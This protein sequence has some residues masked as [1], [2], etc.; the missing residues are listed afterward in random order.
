MPLTTVTVSIAAFQVIGSALPNGRVRFELTA[1]DIDDGIVVP[2]ATTVELAADGTGT[3]EL[4]PNSRGTQGTQYRVMVYSQKGD[5]QEAALA[6]VPETAC[7]LHDILSLEPPASV[8]DA[9]AAALA[10]QAYAAA[11]G[12]IPGAAGDSF[13]RAWGYAT[14]FRLISATR[15]S[16]GAITT[17]TIEW[18]DGTDGVYTA[19][20]LSATFL[21]A[22]DAW[23]AT[24]AGTPSK[25]VTQPAVT[26]NS[27]GAVTVQ[28]AITIA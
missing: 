4:W 16:D 3:V 13:L 11:A 22:T 6:T 5:L 24:Y 17:A 20:T 9:Q 23:H 28:P 18:P 1:A 27:D 7:N 8:D 14:A 19:D 10:A 12:A 25:T 2:M 26:R 15:N 21:G